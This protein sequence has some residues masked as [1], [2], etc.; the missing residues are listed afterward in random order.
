MAYFARIRRKCPS[1]KTT[2]WS[3]HSRRIDPISLSAKPFSQGEP[4]AM[5]LS[6]MPMIA[7]QVARRLSPRECLCH[8]A[9]D[10]FHGRMRCDVDPDRISAGQSNDDE[11]IEQ[12]EANGRGNEE[13]HGREVRRMITHEGAPSLRGRSA[14]LDH[15]LRDAGLSDLKAELEQLAMDARRTP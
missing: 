13:V 7:D 9:R 14:S 12:V 4:E 11:D 2:T 8:L 1:P 15:V 6:R 5:G 3:T 10:P